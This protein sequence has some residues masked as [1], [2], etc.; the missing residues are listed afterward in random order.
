MAL[1]LFRN[2]II[3][4][5]DSDALC[6][7]MI[8]AMTIVLLFGIAGIYVSQSNPSFKDYI[9]MPILVILLSGAV[10]CSTVVRLIK[11]YRHRWER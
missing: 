10:I 7:L 9:W 2:L 4:W 8:L 11:R 5:Y 3:P 1:P 6:Y